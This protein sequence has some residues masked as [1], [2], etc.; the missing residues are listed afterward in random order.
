MTEALTAAASGGRDEL[1]R[2]FRTY[3]SSGDGRISMDEVRH[4]VSRLGMSVGEV[5]TLIAEADA[6]GDES[7]DSDSD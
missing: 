5:S 6:D 7:S 1:R 3:D 4:V 2:A